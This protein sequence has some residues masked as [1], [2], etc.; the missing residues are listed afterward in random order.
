MARG[1]P[2]I[3]AQQTSK[4]QSQAIE[5]H[6][7]YHAVANTILANSALRQTRAVNPNRVGVAGISWGS[8]VAANAIGVDDRFAFAVLVYGSALLFDTDTKIGKLFKP[9]P[10]WDPALRLGQAGAARPLPLLWLAGAADCYFTHRTRSASAQ[11][12]PGDTWLSIPDEM[13]HGHYDG[14]KPKVITAFADGA[15]KGA[16]P[17]PRITN[18]VA[19]G[20][21]VTVT[22]Y[23]D[24]QNPVTSAKLV[25]TIGKVTCLGTIVDKVTCLGP[26]ECA[27]ESSKAHLNKPQSRVTATLPPGTTAWYVNLV[28]QRGLRSSSLLIIVP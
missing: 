1:G 5:D 7:M 9:V 25:S 19:I 8:V 10:Y 22:Y 12:T 4:F 6:W 18:A 16:Q 17:L 2:S 26:P 13:K 14:W 15:V 23:A 11:L 28:D 3:I 24:P 20:N 27:W 21:A